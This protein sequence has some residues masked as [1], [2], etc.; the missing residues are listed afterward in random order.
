MPLVLGFSAGRLE[1]LQGSFPGDRWAAVDIEVF[2]FHSLFLPRAARVGRRLRSEEHTSELQSRLHLVCR[3]LL[4]K[5]TKTNHA[6]YSLRSFKV[7]KPHRSP[8]AS[9]FR[10]PGT[11]RHVYNLAHCTPSSD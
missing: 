9:T 3:L 5:K 8:H 7:Q 2:L 6:L 4:E 11:V 1:L 10:H